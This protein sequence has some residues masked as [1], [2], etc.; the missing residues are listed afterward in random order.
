MSIRFCLLTLCTRL[1]MCCPVAVHSFEPLDQPIQ[2]Y[3]K[4]LQTLGDHIWKRRLDLGRLQK[5]VGAQSNVSTASI[6]LWESDEATSALGVLG[7][8]RLVEFNSG[9]VSKS[10]NSYK[11]NEWAAA[12]SAGGA[13]S[14]TRA[15]SGPAATFGMQRACSWTVF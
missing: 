8:N 12:W 7:T 5:D 6:W 9:G 1:F 13:Q 15:A 10:E 4:S 3:P 14:P 11:P 2:G